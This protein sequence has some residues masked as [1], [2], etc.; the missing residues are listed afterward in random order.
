MS[1]FENRELHVFNLLNAQ[2][3]NK[4]SIKFP[5]FDVAFQVGYP[6]STLMADELPSTVIDVT[7]ISSG[8]DDNEDKGV[9]WHTWHTNRQSPGNCVI[10]QATNLSIM[11]RPPV[12]E[13]VRLYQRPP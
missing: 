11:Q 7:S 10:G 13:E 8:D 1:A 12:L 5:D 2:S 6:C 3:Y 4:M 9:D